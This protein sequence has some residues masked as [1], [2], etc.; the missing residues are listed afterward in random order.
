MSHPV[1]PNYSNNQID[2]AGVSACSSKPGTKQY[3]DAVSII[4]GWRA[5]HSY[6]IH[7]FYV[8]LRRRAL[9]VSRKSLI[10]RR[11]KRLTTILDKIG[12]REG[13][14]RL[15]RMQDI[16]GVRAI[17]PK[18]KHVYLLRDKYV[19]DSRF[20]HILK[21]QHDYIA[22]PK[23]SGYRGIHLVYSFN[24]AQGR[25]SIAREY[26]GLVLEMQI[27]TQFQHEWATAVEIVGT[28]LRTDLKSS[29][30]DK[31]WLEFFQCMSSV[32]ALLEDAPALDVHKDWTTTRLFDRTR[33]LALKINIL[34]NIAGWVAGLKFI[35]EGKG[36][37]YHILLLDIQ[38]KKVRIVRFEESES[39]LANETLANLEEQ[40]AI[41]GTPDPVLVAAGD[42]KKLKK[43][44][45]NYFLDMKEFL[46]LTAQVVETAQDK[47]YNKDN[48]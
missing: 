8:T 30:G 38:S 40:A 34:H 23:P 16:G 39:E 35:N 11:L 9:A 44:Y 25:S 2:R 32:M 17:V 7:T 33:D 4:N 37:Y 1:R 31:D 43:A 28:M 36:G 42:M 13:T 41:N 45:P 21:N 10:A 6:P 3:T 46:L 5:A 48:E 29:V 18:V 24:N 20:P 12:G 27:R 22:S 15:S 19:G 14:M 26:D 47:K